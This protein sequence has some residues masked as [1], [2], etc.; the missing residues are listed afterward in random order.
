MKENKNREF[1]EMVSKTFLNTVSAFANY[2]GGEILFG[3]T[4]DGN[5]VGITNPEQVCLDIENTI[6]DTIK[7]KPDFLFSIDGK[8]KVI[9]LTVKEGLFK[10]Y[11]YK[12]KAYKRS[13]TSTVEVDQVELRRLVLLGENLYFEEL[14]SSNQKLSFK[15]LLDQLDEKLLISKDSK[16]IDILRTLGLMSQD[17]QYNN[18][19]MLLADNNNFPGIDIIKFGSTI[20]EIEY[21]KTI[22]NTSV[23]KQLQEAEDVFSQYYKLEKIE[24]MERKTRFLIPLE[25]FRETVANALV[26]RTWDVNSHIRIAMH[27]DRIEVYSPGGL[28]TGITKEDYIRGY[29]SI[30][31]NPIIGNVFFRLDIIEQFGTGILRIKKAY[32]NLEHQPVFDVTENSVVT[33]LPA[34]NKQDSLTIDEQKI[35]N[36]LLS[37]FVLSSSEISNS[38]GF[39]K[40]KVLN[41]LNILIEKRYVEKVGSGRGTKYKAI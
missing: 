16:D 12:G 17:S 18:A 11:L 14:P 36:I 19:A 15:F 2:S 26:H 25:A 32:Y 31:R 27:D 6:N 39:G 35:F 29:V 33:I 23:L 5:A 40:D 38:A 1:K 9:T 7:P 41:L 28:P 24:G 3:V 8:T 10:P 20:D 21:R 22:S 4:D 13:G 30:L 37:R 34:E